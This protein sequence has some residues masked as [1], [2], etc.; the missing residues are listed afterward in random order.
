M[1]RMH[2]RARWSRW[3]WMRRVL[4]RYGDRWAWRSWF[5]RL[6]LIRR[7]RIFFSIS[8]P[9]ERAGDHRCNHRQVREDQPPLRRHIRSGSSTMSPSGSPTDSNRSSGCSSSSLLGVSRLAAHD[10]T[11]I[12]DLRSAD[13]RRT[14]IARRRLRS[15]GSIMLL[16]P[17]WVAAHLPE[18]ARRTAVPASDRSL[19]G[20][21]VLEQQAPPASAPPLHARCQRCP[22]A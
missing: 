4:R 3:I 1:R 18:G 6:R 7:G 22:P 8:A 10:A 13:T 15:Y 19:A 12:S 14:I 16:P 20:P 2:R 5:V 17:A 21:S 11:I 9:H